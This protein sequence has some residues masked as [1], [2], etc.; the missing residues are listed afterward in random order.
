VKLVWTARASSTSHVA[1]YVVHPTFCQM[2]IFGLKNDSF[3]NALLNWLNTVNE[4]LLA[5]LLKK[6]ARDS[7]TSIDM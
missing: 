2:V 1:A 3:T 5:F 4:H 7:C 6:G